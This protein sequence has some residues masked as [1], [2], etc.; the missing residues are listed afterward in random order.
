MFFAGSV[1]NAFV[2]RESKLQVYLLLESGYREGY[3]W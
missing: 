1:W 2:T 3:R